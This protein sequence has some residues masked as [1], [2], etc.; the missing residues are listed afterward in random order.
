MATSFSAADVRA[1]MERARTDPGFQA[2]LSTAVGQPASHPAVELTTGPVQPSGSGSG[3]GTTPGNNPSSNAI[4]ESTAKGPCLEAQRRPFDS[5]FHLPDDLVEDSSSDGPEST[6]PTDPEQPDERVVLGEVDENVPPLKRQATDDQ[7]KIVAEI[8]AAA[9]KSVHY[10][11]VED[12]ALLLAGYYAC[13][14]HEIVQ[15]ESLTS[16]IANNYQ[17]Q[18]EKLERAGIWIASAEVP[19]VAASVKRHT[20]KQPRVLYDRFKDLKSTLLNVVVPSFR[21]IGLLTS[22]YSKPASGKEWP[23]VVE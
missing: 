7:V 18:A 11:W 3:S 23:E 19:T 16:A 20:A 13:A 15:T 14:N 10:R 5:V 17:F 1:L 2:Y 21:H 12:Y 4:L 22:D 9:D 8:P 6:T